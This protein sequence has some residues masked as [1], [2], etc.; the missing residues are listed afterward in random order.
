MEYL[1]KKYYSKQWISNWMIITADHASNHKDGEHIKV[2]YDGHVKPGGRRVN[3]I[4]K[5]KT[6]DEADKKVYK[7]ISKSPYNF[8]DFEISFDN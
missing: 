6:W 1:G 4:Y 2:W 3:R 8:R 5:C 7:Y